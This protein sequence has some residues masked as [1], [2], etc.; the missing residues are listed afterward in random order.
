MLEAVPLSYSQKVQGKTV[1]PETAGS[2]FEP[3]T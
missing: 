3:R 2:A 1:G